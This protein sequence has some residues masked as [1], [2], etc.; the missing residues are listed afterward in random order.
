MGDTSGLNPEQIQAIS[1]CVE[2]VISLKQHFKRASLEFRHGEYSKVIVPTPNGDVAFG[3]N[4]PLV[5]TNS[6]K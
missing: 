1:P 3:K 4:A 2:T 5:N 6:Q